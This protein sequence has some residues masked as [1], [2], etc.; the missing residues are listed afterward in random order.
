MHERIGG[1]RLE[2][3]EQ[4]RAG[5]AE[6][7]EQR[8]LA[9]RGEVVVERSGPQAAGRRERLHRDLPIP[10]SPERRRGPPVEL[11]ASEQ[12]VLRRASC[13]SREHRHRAGL[14]PPRLTPQ[15]DA[16]P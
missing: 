1:E 13:T 16:R 9:L 3:L 4:V 2:L 11:P 7:R 10:K 6:E 14:L 5:F 12:Q 15:R 8:E